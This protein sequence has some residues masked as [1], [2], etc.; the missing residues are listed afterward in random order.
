MGRALRKEM[1]GGIMSILEIKDMVKAYDG[2][3]IFSG[4]S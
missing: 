4:F 1:E 3:P 2:A